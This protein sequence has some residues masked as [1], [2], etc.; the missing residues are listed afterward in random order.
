MAFNKY[1]FFKILF[2]IIGSVLLIG[3]LA[4]LFARVKITDLLVEYESDGSSYEL[5]LN[6]LLWGLASGLGSFFLSLGLGYPAEK[7]PYNKYLAIKIFSLLIGSLL[8]TLGF[9]GLFGGEQIRGLTIEYEIDLKTYEFNLNLITW[10]VLITIGFIYITIGLK[11]SRLPK[12]VIVS[13]PH[14]R[15]I[16]AILLLLMSFVS[17]LYFGVELGHSGLTG[18]WL[19]L[20]GLS[21]WFPT[22]MFPLIFG[23]VL[24]IFSLF[25]FVK[26]KID[27]TDELLTITESR[28]PRGMIT[29]IPMDKI[30]VIHN[31]NKK[32]GLKFLWI[33]A[34]IISG[35]LLLIDG[36]SFLLNPN[37]FGTAETVAI[38]Y[39]ISGY[40]Q[41]FVMVLLVVSSQH[42]TE[43]VTDDKVYEFQYFPSTYAH[44]KKATLDLML[45]PRE[46]RVFENEIK[47][48]I[49]Q[50]SDLKRVLLGSFLIVLG[51]ICRIY[52]FYA[53]EILR[54]AMFVGGTILFVEGLK[55][56][57]YITMKGLEI[58]SNSKEAS[59]QVSDRSLFFHSEHYF[60]NV[61]SLRGIDT[62]NLRNEIS[63][64]RP[65]KLTI[66]DHIV[67]GG[68]VLLM[69]MESYG[70]MALLP[71][72]K[73][74]FGVN[75]TVMTIILIL[76]LWVV[77]TSPDSVLKVKLGDRNYQ[78]PIRFKEKI[79]NWFVS[80]FTFFIAKFKICWQ[81]ERK[82]VLFR[83]VEIGVA[84]ALGILASFII[85]VT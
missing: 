74:Q 52:H 5:D 54:F 10:A 36:Y 39:L 12:N 20:G 68:L 60:R 28:F 17:F 35:V 44:L 16:S 69:G 43:I 57:I 2:S 27:R 45:N 78:I 18:T 76:M 56:D 79:D 71:A 8:L 15:F 19:F 51:I 63:E 3:G 82:I 62:D 61:P 64:T 84:F 37:S 31:T 22:G 29:E 26:I 42:V 83:I 4:C 67:F 72:S 66:I 59:V 40:V 7:K 13:F 48:P 11:H 65:R 6:V 30:K 25:S 73:V 46:E 14:S 41:L 85:H 53:G 24:L 33:F 1:L 34:F 32:T 38:A 50:R 9:Y 23:T 58:K 47:T 80:F 77:F 21:L 55:N 49:R 75:N 70:I 81:K